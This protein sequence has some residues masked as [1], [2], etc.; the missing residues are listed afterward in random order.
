M[1]P[2][3]L[4]DRERANTV[5]KLMRLVYNMKVMPFFVEIAAIAQP[6]IVTNAEKCQDVDAK[7]QLRNGIGSLLNVL[8][9]S[10]TKT[11]FAQT[12]NKLNA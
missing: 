1:L 11:I 7:Q 10:E 12:F 4:F 3:T 9:D 8:P 5:T 6:I 2:A